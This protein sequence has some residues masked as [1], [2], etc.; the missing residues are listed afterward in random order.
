MTHLLKSKDSQVAK[1]MAKLGEFGRDMTMRLAQIE[2]NRA[3]AAL[4]EM[5]MN[6]H[7]KKRDSI[8]DRYR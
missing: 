4:E 1:M 2:L 7:H 3:K 8:I 6:I 5:E